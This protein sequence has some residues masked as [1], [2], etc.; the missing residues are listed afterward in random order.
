VRTPALAGPGAA[1]RRRDG[2]RLRRLRRLS[3]VRDGIRPG[4]AHHG[5]AT[6][7]DL[8]LAGQSFGTTP[9]RASGSGKPPRDGPTT[10]PSTMSL[11][12]RRRP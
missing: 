3:H 12:P 1:D 9:S 6:V 8:A 2:A 7:A 10:S 4:R 5:G 11:P